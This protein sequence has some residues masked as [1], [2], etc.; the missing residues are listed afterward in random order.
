MAIVRLALERRVSWTCHQR[1]WGRGSLKTPLFP[2]LY[3]FHVLRLLPR[4][5]ESA[6]GLSSGEPI[7]WPWGPTSL[8]QPHR[9]EQ[10]TVCGLCT[11]WSFPV[12]C[13]SSASLTG[14]HASPG[15]LQW[16]PLCAES[17]PLCHAPGGHVVPLAQHA[18]PGLELTH[19]PS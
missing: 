6:P 14:S 12:E 10:G 15:G 19:L 4:H 5:P 11:C 17:G 13:L 16:V 18:T 3:P 8:P 2:L 9:S 1:G 7:H